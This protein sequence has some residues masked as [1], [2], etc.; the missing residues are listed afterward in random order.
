MRNDDKKIDESMPAVISFLFQCFAA[1]VLATCLGILSV[2]ITGW[3][4]DIYLLIV[5]LPV[6]TLLSVPITVFIGGFLRLVAPISTR[7][8]GRLAVGLMVAYA[9]SWCFDSM[10][11]PKQFL[12][13]IEFAI[14]FGTPTALLVGSEIRPWRIFTFGTV[15]I[16]EG[17]RMF[18]E[19]SSNVFA[20][21]G[22][23]PLRLLNIYLLILIILIEATLARDFYRDFRR[24]KVWFI[25]IAIAIFVICYLVSGIYLSYRTPRTAFLASLVI[26]L[27][28]P[29][30]ALALWLYSKKNTGIDGPFFLG[31]AVILM[32]YLMLWGLCLVSRIV[33]ARLI[34]RK[35]RLEQF[36]LLNEHHCLGERMAFW[37]QEW[38]P[39]FGGTK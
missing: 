9:I 39:E 12:S 18:R 11:L 20:L 36:A 15:T 37:Q 17:R 10:S 33:A 16:Y 28:A 25:G 7:L 31:A 34:Q 3:D 23:L 13:P 38:S 22:S 14:C 27:N 5:F 30:I 6:F 29:E 26:L 1:A 4:S 8:P 35:I 19:T 21:L 24:E 2:L 32:V